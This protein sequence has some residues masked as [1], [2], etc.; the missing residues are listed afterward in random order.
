MRRSIDDWQQRQH[1]LT[2][3]CVEHREK[4]FYKVFH[5]SDWKSQSL[6][7][8]LLLEKLLIV[9]TLVVDDEGENGRCWSK[10]FCD[11]TVWWRPRSLI[12]SMASWASRFS[13]RILRNVKDSKLMKKFNMSKILSSHLPDVSRKV[14]MKSRPT[15]SVT[16]SGSMSDKSSSSLSLSTEMLQMFVLTRPTSF[17][18]WT[19]ST[20]PLSMSSA[21]RDDSVRHCVG[22]F[23][24]WTKRK[25]ERG[26]LVCDIWGQSD[27]IRRAAASARR[28][29]ESLLKSQI[30]KR[31]R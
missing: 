7:C 1:I 22:C 31:G 29:V 3:N 12:N 9:D 15:M 11:E 5:T 2:L 28:W 14:S 27:A 26:K 4:D 24:R 20:L 30:A 10:L 21:L 13:V 19:L 6:Y 18:M 23:C 16:D 8:W 25:N 17:C